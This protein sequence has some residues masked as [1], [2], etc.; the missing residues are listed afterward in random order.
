MSS[1]RANGESMSTSLSLTTSTRP[2]SRPLITTT[3]IYTTRPKTAD[4]RL[5]DIIP[6]SQ[7]KRQASGVESGNDN[8]GDRVGPA[9]PRPTAQRK[10]ESRANRGGRLP[11]VQQRHPIGINLPPMSAITPL[12]SILLPHSSTPSSTSSTTSATSSPTSTPA[13]HETGDNHKTIIGAVVGSVCGAL[14]VAIALLCMYK[15]RRRKAAVQPIGDSEKRTNGESSRQ[16]TSPLVPVKSAD[17][18]GTA[19]RPESQ[20]G[21]QSLGTPQTEGQAASY[22][23]SLPGELADAQKVPLM[24]SSPSRQ[25]TG[26]SADRPESSSRQLAPFPPRYSVIQSEGNTD[27]TTNRGYSDASAGSRVPLMSSNDRLI[28]ITVPSEPLSELGSSFRRRASEDPFLDP[29]AHDTTNAPSVTT[30]PPAVVDMTPRNSSSSSLLP[31]QRSRSADQPLEPPPNKR[32]PYVSLR[33]PLGRPPSVETTKSTEEVIL[34][35]SPARRLARSGAPT[36]S[37]YQEHGA[38]YRNRDKTSSQESGTTSILT[39]SLESP[40][41]P[42]ASIVDSPSPLRMSQGISIRESMSDASEGHDDGAE[43]G[44]PLIEGGTRRTQH[45]DNDQQPQ[46]T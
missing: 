15:W 2:A 28:R 29:P 23:A 18:Q 1:T 7:Q 10:W 13:S 26:D 35:P 30:P 20:N 32:V 4:D 22:F 12:L 8:V 40:I 39:G 42:G 17:G 36:D 5:Y 21:P 38:P 46:Q 45:H 24:A 27:N 43:P 31:K 33:S 37:A 44:E 3:V 41:I 6:E 25:R 34:R 9:T 14:L 11:L 16:I 19:P